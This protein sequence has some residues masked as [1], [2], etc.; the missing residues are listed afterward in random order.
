[1]TAAIEIPLSLLMAFIL[2]RFAGMNLN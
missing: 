2:M 1:V